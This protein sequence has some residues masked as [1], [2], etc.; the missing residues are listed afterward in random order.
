MSPE[1][2]FSGKSTGERERGGE[3]EAAGKDGEERIV[4]V[5]EKWLPF[6]D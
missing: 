6:P 1:N 2:L 3:I 4:W 5:G